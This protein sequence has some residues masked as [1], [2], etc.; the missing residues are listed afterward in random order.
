M[1]RSHTDCQ[2]R[3]EGKV[4]HHHVRQRFSV[5]AAMRS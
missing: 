4:S 2:N 5:T 3:V 1:K